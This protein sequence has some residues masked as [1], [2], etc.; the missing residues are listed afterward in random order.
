MKKVGILTALGLVLMLAGMSVDRAEAACSLYIGIGQDEEI[1]ACLGESADGKVTSKI[2]DNVLTITLN[3]Y[4][5]KMP[6]FV[7]RGSG[8]PIEKTVVELEGENRVVGSSGDGTVASVLSAELTGE[9]SLKIYTS[10]EAKVADT[11]VVVGEDM[12]KDKVSS[13]E[14][15]KTEDDAAK[16]EDGQKTEVDEGWKPTVFEIVSIVYMVLSVAIIVILAVKCC[17]KQ[18]QKRVLKEDTSSSG[19]RAGEA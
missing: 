5:G 3:N 10:E 15:P 11:V 12:E 7:N 19:H 8:V 1:S 6:E 9:G 16:P 4:D 14:D 13:E 2:D 17:K 18:E